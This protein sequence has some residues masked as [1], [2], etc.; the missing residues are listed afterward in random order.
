MSLK[1]ELETWTHALEAYDAS[2]LPRSL[3]IFTTIAESSKV[4]F[5]IGLIHA[6]QGH[7]IQAIRAFKQATELDRFFAVAYFQRGVSLFLTAEWERAKIQFE[8][9]LS[10]MRGNDKM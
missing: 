2:D 4:H 10:N 7:H 1:A 8:M 6:T 5:N 3:E 9:A